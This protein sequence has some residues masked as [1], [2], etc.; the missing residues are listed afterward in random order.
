M[1]RRPREDSHPG[2]SNAM[3]R[4]IQRVDRDPTLRRPFRAALVLLAAAL[5][6]IAQQPQDPPVATQTVSFARQP[7]RV[8]DQVE[9]T[10]AI[11]MRLSTSRRQGNE[12]VETTTVTARNYQRRLVTTT[13]I[14]EGRTRAVLVRYFEATKQREAGDADAQVG[15]IAGQPNE[16]SSTITK[17]VSGKSY[18]CRRE[19]DKLIVTDAQGNIPPP[20]EV[21]IVAADMEAVGRPNP[22]VDFL[23][24]RTVAVGET[25]ALPMDVADRL[26][27]I[28]SKFGKLT[29][30]DLAL[31]D[32]RTEGGVTCAVFQASIVAASHGSSQMR[33]EL[34][35]PLA[36]QINTCRAARMGL[37]GPLGLSAT[38]GRNSMAYHVFGTGKLSMNIASAY[39][40]A[41]R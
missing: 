14:A 1:I 9:Q 2:D 16:P 40:D 35:G 7:S 37:T 33:L 24:G 6:A 29:R 17:P 20:A 39:R 10:I 3:K 22:L 21:E 5:S 25:L 27:G 28:G 12:L 4:S 34:A 23:A 30:F 13:E 38:G 18:R 19:G 8:G 11:D 36:V 26:L 15:A 32:V 41:F 31:R